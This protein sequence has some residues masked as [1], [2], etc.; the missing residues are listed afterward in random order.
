MEDLSNSLC[1]F[2]FQTNAFALKLHVCKQLVRGET[3]CSGS[4]QMLTADGVGRA[5]ARS[6][7]LDSDVPLPHLQSALGFGFAP[8]LFF[9][10]SP[11]LVE[12]AQA[13]LMPEYLY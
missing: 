6:Q 4:L 7:Q 3:F 1:N 12:D 5:E 13:S 11:V 9:L 8:F 2:A 10:S